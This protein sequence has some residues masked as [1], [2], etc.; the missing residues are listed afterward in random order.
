MQETTVRVGVGFEVP[1]SLA[2]A[3]L[4]K[5]VAKDKKNRLYF[6]SAEDRSE[7]KF[8]GLLIDHELGTGSVARLLSAGSDEAWNEE[9]ERLR[10]G[11]PLRRVV[12]VHRDIVHFQEHDLGRRVHP[13]LV[14]LHDLSPEEVIEGLR[15]G[16]KTFVALGVPEKNLKVSSA[17]ADWS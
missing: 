5:S 14:R 2:S 8:S 15:E 7:E 1:L 13:C 6:E 10:L 3:A 9:V 4:L 11:S 12:T 17:L 16:V